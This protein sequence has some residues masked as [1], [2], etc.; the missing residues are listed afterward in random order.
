VV[1]VATPQI[2]V[3]V[4]MESDMEM[5]DGVD[6][7]NYPW[8]LSTPLKLDTDLIRTANLCEKISDEDLANLGSIV[9]QDFERDL[10]SR[11]EWKERMDIAMK[12]AMQTN[13]IKTFPWERAANVKFPLITIAALQ[14]QSRAY[15]A[16]IN[17]PRPV[18]ARPLA[19]MPHIEMPPPSPP[20]PDGKPDPR[21]QLAQQQATA[22]AQMAKRQYD[23]LVRKGNAIA[24][25]MSYQILEEDE[26]W[27]EHHDKL[28]LQLPI[29]G[30]SFKKNYFDP[31]LCRNVSECVSPR[32]LVVDYYAKDVET[33]PRLSHVIYLSANE[34]HT[35]QVR[36]VFSDFTEGSTPR[37]EPRLIYELDP[38]GDERDGVHQMPGDHDA[39]FEFIEQHRTLDLDGDGY[40]EPYVVTVRYD[41][42][43]VVRIVA[44]FTRKDVA[45]S[46]DG[47]V[48]R[49]EPIQAFTRY[50]F[51]ASPD[52][53]FYGLGF[54]ALLGPINE[55]INSAINQM[56]D[57]A[58]LANAGGGFMGRG[59]KNKK[60]EYRFRPGEWKTVDSTGDDLRKNIM[61][62][63]AQQPSTVMFQL[64][65][66][67]IEY[68]EGIAGAV[69]VMQ[70]KNPGQNTPAETT[71]AMVEQ[72][73]KVFNGIYKRVHRAFTQELRHLFRLNCTFLTP[74]MPYFA[75]SAPQI[76]Q[77]A[78]PLYKDAEVIIRA[79][80]DPFYMS[81]G[82]RYN[83]AV[84]LL[85]AAGTSP[86]YDPYEVHK[87]YLDA[88]KLPDIDRFLPDPSGPFA[89]PPLP[90]PKLQIEQLKQQTK[91]AQMQLDF[92]MKL[93][94]LVQSAELQ[95]AQIKLLEA[96]VVETL[97]QA[98][99]VDT[100]HQIA[101]IEA[102]IG[103]AKNK[104]EGTLE[105][106]KLL[107]SVMG[108][109]RQ[110]Q[111][112]DDG[113]DQGGGGGLGA[114]VGQPGNDQAAGNVAGALGGL[115]GGGASPFPQ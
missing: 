67:L 52:G 16:L 94:T 80:A 49:I 1:S 47:R 51:I 37:P 76:S 72:G 109:D 8:E 57:A 113:Q 84:A 36:G 110:G 10:R 53:G 78:A 4:R 73:M 56:L 48:I 46:H 26:H 63:P 19:S 98:K 41:T 89:R 42:R 114:L 6:N 21:A 45:F 27:E 75:Q 88:L 115:G 79:A 105:A 83:Q 23:D 77:Q 15:P 9:V 3:P 40:A 85:S 90:N 2:N 108:G 34:V 71:R 101:L 112:G 97:A 18:S 12:L 43:Q 82:Q 17:G 93:L 87:Y 31:I 107:H 58:T 5:N 22:K 69:D 54:G 30:C 74:D 44:R 95:A 32:D 102:Q 66:L 104:Q 62:L 24:K 13:E 64:V 60:G 92:K 35:R 61:P 28:L 25:H 50:V 39:P 103:A 106:I 20:G 59:F 91:Q 7:A 99:G 33:A 14:F 100:G 65:T 81:D 111:G 70:G 68:G 55:T 96:Q 29:M 86:L 11:D 38:Y